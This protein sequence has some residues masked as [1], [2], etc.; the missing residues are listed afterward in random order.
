MITS[1]LKRRF[2]SKVFVTGIPSSWDQ[3]E[4]KSK[5]EVAGPVTGVSLVL[6][7]L[8][9]QTGKA[10]VQFESEDSVKDAVNHFNDKAWTQAS[11]ICKVSEYTDTKSEKQG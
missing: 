7:Q 8:G 3:L 9:Q 11:Q 2:T 5:F 4:V 6:N 1:I 10:I